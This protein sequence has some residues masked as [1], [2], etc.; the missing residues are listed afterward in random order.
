MDPAQDG[1]DFFLAEITKAD[2][3]P[4]ETFSFIKIYVLDLFLS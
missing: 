1:K 4:S 2:H 3:Q